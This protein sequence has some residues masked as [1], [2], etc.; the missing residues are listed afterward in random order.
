MVNIKVVSFDMDGTLTD[1]SFVESVWLEGV[2][3]LFAEKNGISFQDATTLVKSEYDKVGRDR[4]EWYDLEY[5][6]RKLSLNATPKEI[7][8]SF[9][10]RVKTFPEV[11]E[12]LQA[13]KEKGFRL[14]I[15]SNARREFL[16]L[17][18]EKTGIG[19]F[20]GHT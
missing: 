8:S 15:V 11:T 1:L 4:L 14:I 3:R 7:L 16:D 12:V 6:T 13:L 17:E 2:P 5:W 10:H 20:F 18:L 9:Q 19:Y